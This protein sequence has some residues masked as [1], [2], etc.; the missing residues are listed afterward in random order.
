MTSD[1]EHGTHQLRWKAEIWGI[2]RARGEVE[3]HWHLRGQTQDLYVLKV[4]AMNF[5]CD[6]REVVTVSSYKI[7]VR[8]DSGG[9]PW[10]IKTTVG[11]AKS[12]RGQR[13]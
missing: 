8:A 10:L 1:T 11:N 9:G 4:I 6:A 2:Q 3:E 7:C 13:R 12:L 5:G